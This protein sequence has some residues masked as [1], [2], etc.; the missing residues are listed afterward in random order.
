MLG[1]SLSGAKTTWSCNEHR[2]HGK[3]S[4]KIGRWC[5]HGP[6][7]ARSGKTQVPRNEVECVVTLL[8]GTSACF[9]QCSSH[10]IIKTLVGNDGRRERYTQPGGHQSRADGANV[11]TAWNQLASLS[12]RSGTTAGRA[13]NTFRDS[14][15]TKAARAAGFHYKTSI[16]TGSGLEGHPVRLPFFQPRAAPALDGT[17]CSCFRARH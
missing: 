14:Q 13:A 15:N 6:G 17:F 16:Q 2:A 1:D 3:K 5:I 8:R 11:L 7:A 4:E 9:P 10:H 12:D